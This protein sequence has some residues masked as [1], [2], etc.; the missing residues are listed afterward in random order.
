MKTKVKILGLLFMSMVLV[1]SCGKDDEPVDVSVTT[2]VTTEKIFVKG[3]IFK[4]GSPEGVGENNERPQRQVTLSDFYISK[5]EVT[6]AEYAKFLNAKGNQEEGGSTWLDITNNFCQIEKAGKTFKA[7]AG[8]ENHPV[9]MVTWYGAK[10]YASWAGGRLPTE[11]EW[12]Y[13]AGGG[14]KSKG[15]KYS[16]SNK[17]NEV[18]WYRENSQI[19]EK[20]ISNGKGTHP[21]GKKKPNELG[22]YDMTGNVWEWC[23]DWYGSY[24]SAAE[25]NPQG[26]SS[27]SERVLRGGSWGNDAYDCRVAYRDSYNPSSSY[28]FIGFRIIIIP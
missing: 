9:I 20:A 23:S 18:A 28:Y 24:G 17:I 10:A 27:G 1:M 3:G 14:N 4:M 15:Y 25:T 11:A 6:N 5:Y 22:I 7:K 16:G 12:E 13:A 21:I 19:I 26:A 2:T 8:K